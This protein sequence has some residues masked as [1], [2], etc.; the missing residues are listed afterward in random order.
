M[1]N[2]GSMQA[3][4]GRELAPGTEENMDLVSE[5]QGLSLDFSNH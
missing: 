5:S 1:G 3:A 2:T 4:L